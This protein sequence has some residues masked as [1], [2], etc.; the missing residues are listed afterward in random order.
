MNFN[1]WKFATYFLAVF[2]LIG[3]G[4]FI[5]K[6]VSNQNQ[7][8]VLNDIPVAASQNRN[9]ILNS[10]SSSIVTKDNK[11]T[12]ANPNSTQ[13]L[14]NNIAQQITSSQNENQPIGVAENLAEKLLREKI[15]NESKGLIKL[16]K[17]SKTNGQEINILG[18]PLYK[19]EY[20]ASIEFLDDCFWGNFYLDFGE[21]YK[22]KGN[23]NTY[24]SRPPSIMGIPPPETHEAG[25]KGKRT[26]VKGD[27]ILEKTEK[28]WRVSKG[29]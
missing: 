7:L 10:N 5:G 17:F 1:F 8:T 16:V 22:W 18:M 24:N 20:D 11:S 26:E 25:E 3:L 4:V 9:I 21:G 27:L 12:A 28:G 15:Q 23:F 13:N 29:L 2:L 19:V 14:A 6:M